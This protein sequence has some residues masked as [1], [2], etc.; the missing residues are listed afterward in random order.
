M[1]YKAVSPAE[2]KPGDLVRRHGSIST[3]ASVAPA[4]AHGSFTITFADGSV[5]TIAGPV[6][7]VDLLGVDAPLAIHR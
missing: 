1:I 4:S 6:T 7:V 5:V 2:L 3:V